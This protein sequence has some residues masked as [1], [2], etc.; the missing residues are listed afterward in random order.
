MVRRRMAGD[1]RGSI[2]GALPL[3]P[4]HGKQRVGFSFASPAGLE[5]TPAAALCD[6]ASAAPAAWEPAIEALGALGEAVGAPPHVYG[7]LLWTHLTGL[8]YL[9]ETSDLD[10][11]WTVPDA[12]IA[13]ALL[14]GLTRIDR[15]SPVHLDGELV[16]PDGGGVN[17][18]EWDMARKD[19]RDV[20]VKTMDGVTTRPAAA[21]FTA[22]S[23]S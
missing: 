20:L 18:R 23:V 12:A 7:A 16:L 3:P 6:A 15:H 11:L 13:A 4:S 22:A 17:W 5:A 8:S 1:P 2:P 14:S 9:T 10:L 21:L 19:G